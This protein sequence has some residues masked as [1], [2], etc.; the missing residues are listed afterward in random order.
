MEDLVQVAKIL[1]SH[2]VKGELKIEPMNAHTGN[3]EGRLHI[4][5]RF[6]TTKEVHIEKVRW[7]KGEGI[8]KLKEI[9]DRLEADHYARGFL[10]VD[11]SQLAPLPPGEYYVQDLIGL[12]VRNEANKKV[13]TVSD[14][15][16]HRPHD[17]YEID[18]GGKTCLIPA[19]PEIVKEIDFEK[20][21]ITIHVIEG[22]L[23]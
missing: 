11:R 8:I 23:D 10:L 2:G 3:L 7:A 12:E 22:L 18:T 1:R 5:D 16:S 9:S 21:I 14:I 19:V 20:K 17:L 15:F 6:Q 4:A 13:G